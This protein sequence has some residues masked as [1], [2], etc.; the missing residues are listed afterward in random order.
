LSEENLASVKD[1]KQCLNKRISFGSPSK[2]QVEMAIKSLEEKKN[3]LF[4]QY[5]KR[6]DKIKY[7]KDLREKL[8]KDLIS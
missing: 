3:L 7:T 4:N 8:I 1:L 2:E 6:I 5:Q